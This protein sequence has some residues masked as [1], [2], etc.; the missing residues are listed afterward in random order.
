MLEFLNGSSFEVV[1]ACLEVKSVAMGLRGKLQH[2]VEQLEVLDELVRLTGPCTPVNN[3]D[4]ELEEVDK[5]P[6]RS[7]LSKTG[8]ILLTYCTSPSSTDVMGLA[9]ERV[10]RAFLIS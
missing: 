1:V 9:S 2:A 3:R 8:S 6:A 5:L 10:C 7:S 4:V